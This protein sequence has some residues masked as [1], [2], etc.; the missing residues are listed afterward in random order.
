VQVADRLDVLAVVVHRE[1]LQGE[2][3][4]GVAGVDALERIAI[5]DERHLAARQRAGAKIV[6][7]PRWR[8]DLLP[9]G[10]AGVGCKFLRGELHERTLVPRNVQAT[11]TKAAS[12]SDA[13]GRLVGELYLTMKRPRM[14]QEFRR[15]GFPTRHAAQPPGGHVRTVRQGI[16]LPTMGPCGCAA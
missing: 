15:S 10:G 6:H 13:G 9:V 8:A 16:V 7:A 3:V 2:G 14:Q 11:W 12:P 4:R 1:E 5:A